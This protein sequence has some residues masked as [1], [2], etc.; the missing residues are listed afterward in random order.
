MK[1]Y[2]EG[3][4]V[5]IYSSSLLTC[6]CGMSNMQ[7]GNVGFAGAFQTTPS[8]ILKWALDL[9]FYVIKVQITC[10]V[11]VVSEELG[12]I[13]TCFDNNPLSPIFLH[14][15]QHR[16]TRHS[17]IVMWEPGRTVCLS[18]L[19]STQ[20]LHNHQQYR[21]SQWSSRSYGF[22]QLFQL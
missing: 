19:G 18:V 5:A 3:Q 20:Q 7:Q 11:S 15:C 8:H 10:L 13:Q 21:S 16:K 12:Q 17:V 4:N 2:F 14:D 1:L 22:W 6:S 9:V